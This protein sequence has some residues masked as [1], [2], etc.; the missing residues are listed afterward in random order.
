MP[1]NLFRTVLSPQI[2]FIPVPGAGFYRVKY[3][4]PV[5]LRMFSLDRPTI[6][7]KNKKNHTV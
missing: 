3:I 6:Q 5:Y 4:N 7:A 1:K 2:K